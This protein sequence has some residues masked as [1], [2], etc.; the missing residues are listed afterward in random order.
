MA[1]VLS[2]YDGDTIT[3]EAPGAKGGKEQVR[4]LGI[5]A[6][7]LENANLGITGECYGEQSAEA[8]RALLTGSVYIEVDLQIDLGQGDAQHEY[9][10]KYGRLLRYVSVGLDSANYYNATDHVD[11]SDWQLQHG[12]AWVYEQYPVERTPEYMQDQQQA[13]ANHAGLWAACE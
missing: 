12:N 4:I 9:R 3:V 13:Q 2:V 6:P 1:H 5:D 7:E 11:V 10:D 8:L